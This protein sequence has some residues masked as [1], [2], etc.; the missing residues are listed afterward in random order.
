VTRGPLVLLCCSLGLGSVAP[1]RAAADEIVVFAAASLT[2]VLED[3]G[4]TWEGKN[5]DTV[6][7]NFGASNDLARQIKAGAPA[8][9]FFSADLPRME[10]VERAGL[11]DPAD[12]R[13]VLSNVLV[14]VVPK[15]AQTEITTP[16]DLTRCTKIAVADPDAVPAGVYAKRYLESQGLWSAIAAKV[17]PTIDVRAAL[18][19]VEGEHVDAGIVYRTDS[20]IAKNVRVAFEVSR[21]QGPPIVYPVAPLK[22]SRKAG[23]RGF[24]GFL[25][26]SEARPTYERFGFLVLAPR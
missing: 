6:T 3:L 10:E 5:E 12:R 7:F 11:V 20:T 18:A 2:D 14:V 1:Q 24:V 15:A 13:A 21:D 8:D 19:A 16:R 23:A 9:V 17:V 26:S 25:Q 4:K 22:A